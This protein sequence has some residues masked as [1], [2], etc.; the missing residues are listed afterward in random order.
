[1]ITIPYL[2]E[3]LSTVGLMVIIVVF[4]PELRRIFERFGRTNISKSFFLNGRALEITQK[5]ETIKTLCNTCDNLSKNKT[6][7][8][9]VIKKDDS[10][11]DIEQTGVILDAKITSELFLNIFFVNTPLHDGAVIIDDDK[12]RAAGCILPL[13]QK[14]SLNKKYGTRHRAGIGVSENSDALALIVSEER[15]AI[16]VAHKGELKSIKS[17]EQLRNFLEGELLSPKNEEQHESFWHM[18]KNFKTRDLKK[19][20]LRD[21]LEP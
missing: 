7:A 14:R 20:K 21:T 1:M 8:L 18:L 6:G 4:Q 12:I 2:L 16:S 10:L 3:K 11:D 13:T 15:G 9:I 17:K 19:K 5:I